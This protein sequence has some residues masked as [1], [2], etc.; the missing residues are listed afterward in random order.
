MVFRLEEPVLERF[1]SLLGCN[2]VQDSLKVLPRVHRII[3]RQE[4]L[5]FYLRWRCCT[6]SLL[7]SQQG[8]V[9]CLQLR[10]PT[11]DG[12]GTDVLTWIVSSNLCQPAP[13]LI[14]KTSIVGQLSTSC[15]FLKLSG[16]LPSTLSSGSEA[17][18]CATCLTASALSALLALVWTSTAL[19]KQSIHV[20]TYGYIT[21][22][23]LKQAVI[24]LQSANTIDL[25]DG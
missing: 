9:V 8:D 13:I 3:Q 14:S 18:A 11:I 20:S 1:V 24:L 2:W 15:P 12:P 5:K 10:S 19:L 16:S 6:I 7:T 25:P 22:K 21:E 17:S 23:K 4:Q